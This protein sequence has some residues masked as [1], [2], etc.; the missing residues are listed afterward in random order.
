MN[1]E[2]VSLFEYL[3][4]PAGPA[5]GWAIAIRAKQLGH[6]I[7]RRFVKTARYQGNINVYDKSML[8]G[9]YS[10]PANIALIMDDEENYIKRKNKAKEQ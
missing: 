4:R 6:P 2:K 7:E 5:L 10:D 1:N 9:F 3:N 8:D